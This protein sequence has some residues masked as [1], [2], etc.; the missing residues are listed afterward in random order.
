MK[1]DISTIDYANDG[2]IVPSKQKYGILISVGLLENSDN[3]AEIQNHLIG[4]LQANLPK[5]MTECIDYE[6]INME[7]LEPDG[8]LLSFMLT[9]SGREE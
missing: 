4:F 9:L 6:S 1:A 3:C 2:I 7:N 8:G 5:W